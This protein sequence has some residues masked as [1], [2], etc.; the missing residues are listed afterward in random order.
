[1]PRGKGRRKLRRDDETRELRDVSS[2]LE[3]V[4]VIAI[5]KSNLKRAPVGEQC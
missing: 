4:R 5:L 3:A 1:M 2:Q